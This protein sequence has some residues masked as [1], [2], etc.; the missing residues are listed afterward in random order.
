VKG[1]CLDRREFLSLSANAASLSL[2]S[3]VFAARSLPKGELTALT[4]QEA[5]AQIRSRAVSPVEL[6]QACLARIERY[7]SQI[8]AFITVSTELALAQAQA[9]EREIVRGRR[10]GPLHGIPI[11][12]KD[13]I[14]TAGIRTTA[15]SDGLSDRIPLEDAEVVRRLKRAGAVILGKLNMWKFAVTP[16]SSWGPVHNPWELKHEAGGSSSGSAAALAAEYCFGT[17]GTDTG[18][19]VR[20]PAHCCGVVGLKPTYG[21]VSQRGVIPLVSSL[22]HVG[23]L[24]RSVLDAALSLQGMAGYQPSWNVKSFGL[25]VP[26]AG[27]F[28]NLDAE[29]EQLV[30]AALETMRKIGTIR[31]ESVIVPR[32]LDIC[33][34]VGA[35]ELCMD[36]APLID[37]AAERQ[38]PALSNDTLVSIVKKCT[39]GN[40]RDDRYLQAIHALRD[41]RRRAAEV[42]PDG[43]DLLVLPTWKQLPLTIAERRATWPSEEFAAAQQW[44]VQPFN[45]LGLPAISVPCGYA[46]NGLPVGVQIVGRP[47]EESRVLAFAQAYEQATQWHL[48]RPVPARGI[49]LQARS[50]KS[51]VMHADP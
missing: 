49:C 5:G 40:H 31:S 17:V 44:N 27:C 10:R 4:L 29:V 9:A 47:F 15:A 22:D 16:E 32:N 36:V 46:R 26:R 3:P 11:A 38:Q 1:W 7:D 39:K 45:V 2:V 28:E 6:T 24:A 43:V 33:A 35:A 34:A 50:S 37:K 20:I 14:D 18:G 41:A 25:G 48:R 42:F 13:N 8:N 12:L 30:E 51:T 23:P 19:S 21:L